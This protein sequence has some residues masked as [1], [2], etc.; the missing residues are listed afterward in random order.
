MPITPD[1]ARAELARRELARRGVPLDKPIEQKT[2]YKQIIGSAVKNMFLRPMSAAKDLGTNPETMAGAMPGLL[3]TAGAIS[4]IPGG[5][6]MG[7]GI[8]QGVRDLSLKAMKKPVP[9]LMQHGLELGGAALGDIA[10]IPY[11]KGKVFGSQIGEAEKSAGLLTRAPTKSVTPGSVG[12]TLNNLEAQIDAGAI[13]TAQGARDAKSVVNQVY[14]NPKIYES[15]SDIKVQSA[16]VSKKVQ[17]LL[18]K[19]VPGRLGPSQALGKSQTIP[20]M[21]R[22]GYTATPWAIKRGAEGALG[23]E[24]VKKLLGLSGHP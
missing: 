21:I 10:A 22:R 19:M 6:T 23:F 9:G 18:N 13:N 11:V 1:E 15:T 17:E 7:T 16:R 12:E 8:G 20:N 5:A 3:G 2:D 24:I 14:K 4:P